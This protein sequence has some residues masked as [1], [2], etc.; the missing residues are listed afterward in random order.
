MNRLPLI[1]ACFVCACGGPFLASC[2]RQPAPS[3]ATGEKR[4]PESYRVRFETSKGDFL[5]QVT[6]SWAPLGADRFYTL[7]SSG[8]YDGARFFRVLPGFVVQFG[9]AADPAV[10]AKWKDANLKDDPVTQSNRRGTLSF[11]TGGPDTRTTQVFINVAD[12]ARLDANGF[13]PI[14]AVT[15]GMDVVDQFYSGY[16]EGAPRGNGPDQHRIETEGTAYLARDF[17][18]LDYIKKASIEK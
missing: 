12:N 15:S 16:G 7:V 13:A 6:R 17:P 11:A 9:I 4:A 1:L 10:T 8:F 18:K 14:G 2:S 5:V 3:E